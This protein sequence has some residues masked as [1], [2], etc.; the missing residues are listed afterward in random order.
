MTRK[1]KERAQS[2][3]ATAAAIEVNAYNGGSEFTSG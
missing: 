3:R 1:I 2:L